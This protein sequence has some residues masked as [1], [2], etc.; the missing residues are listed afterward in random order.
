MVIDRG[1]I[2]FEIIYEV[3]NSSQ[4]RLYQNTHVASGVLSKGIILLVTVTAMA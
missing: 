1:G 3:Y 4:G 2:S